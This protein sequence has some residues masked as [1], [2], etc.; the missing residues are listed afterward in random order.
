VDSNDHQPDINNSFTLGACTNMTDTDVDQE[1]P[2]IDLEQRLGTV[3]AGNGSNTSS[4]EL[5][6]LIEATEKAANAAEAEAKRLHAEARAIGCSN[7]VELEQK[8]LAADLTVA[9]LD[10]ALPKLDAKLREESAADYSRKWKLRRDRAVIARETV[11]T[12]LATYR[13]MA[14]Q[15]VNIFEEVRYLD[16]KII[17]PVNE[18][19]PANEAPL[20][21][22]ELYARK[23]DAFSRSM[24]SILATVQL[25]NWESSERLV[26]PP[27]TI[28]A[29]VLVAESM[30]ALQHNPAWTDQWA[31]V[32]GERDE[33][34]K[35]EQQKTADYHN[36]REQER[37]ERQAQE[38][39][40]AAA[41]RQ[42]QGYP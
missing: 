20:Q 34:I 42:R 31:S 30:G 7:S 4:S 1:R 28:P 35:A 40:L 29:S 5:R 38:D 33:M 26:W 22:C 13:E 17:A 12:R 24:P 41:E 11:A 16:A 39:A 27:R 2:R 6:E 36:R 8:A 10:T 23:L 32:R 37:L 19:R 3:L 9:R 15:L 25:P 14:A 21:T 18:S